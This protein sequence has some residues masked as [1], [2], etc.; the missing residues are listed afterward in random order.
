MYPGNPSRRPAFFSKVHTAQHAPQSNRVPGDVRRGPPPPSSSFQQHNEFAANLFIGQV[1]RRDTLSSLTALLNQLA[2]KPCVGAI[3]IERAPGTA[4]RCAF[5]FIIDEASLATI[6][7]FNRQ[8]EYAGRDSEEN[9]M[10]LAYV[11]ERKHV[12]AAVSPPLPYL[13]TMTAASSLNL[14]QPTHPQGQFAPRSDNN[15][16]IGQIPFF[17]STGDMRDML[18]K[19]GGKGC[20]KQLVSALNHTAFA[21]IPNPESLQ[22]ILNAS[23]T[24]AVSYTI[25]EQRHYLNFEIPYHYR[26]SAVTHSATSMPSAPYAPR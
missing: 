1:R 6:L 9:P 8:I 24:D 20:V 18:E 4:K 10:R 17:Y 11:F 12:T 7:T 3:T 23:G 25:G 26:D 19:L 16:F 13:Q 14:F 5:A 22:L 2:E 21:N 15:L